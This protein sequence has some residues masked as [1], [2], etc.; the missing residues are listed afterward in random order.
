[1]KRAILVSGF[2]SFLF[3]TFS[4]Q[5]ILIAQ[6]SFSKDTI[7]TAALEIMNETTYCALVTVDSTG[8]PQVRTMN[9][10]PAND[11]LITW[12]GTSRYSRKVREIRN[13]PKVAVYYADHLNAKGYVNISGIAE[14]IDDRDVLM[15]MKRDY[16]ESI[17]DWKENF[18]LIKIIPVT[19]EVINYRHKLT[20]EP[21]TFKAPM[22]ILK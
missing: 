15:K 12:F 3:L 7:I 17:P 4:Y 16:W 6:Q 1:M 10:Y 18:V 2:L 19:V 20:N 8:Q 14:I 22:V 5:G 11:E 13:N 9:P 21:K